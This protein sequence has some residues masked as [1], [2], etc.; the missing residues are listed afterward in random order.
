M[1]ISIYNS[2]LLAAVV[3]LGGCVFSPHLAKRTTPQALAP[4]VHYDELDQTLYMG[5]D[6]KYHYFCRYDFIYKVSYKIPVTDLH[7]DHPLPLRQQPYDWTVMRDIL[8]KIH[9]KKAGQ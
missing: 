1:G 2:T 7:L 8:A 4:M 5:S 3:L 9:Q 6:S